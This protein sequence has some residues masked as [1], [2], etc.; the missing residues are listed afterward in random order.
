MISFLL[1]LA[2]SLLLLPSHATAM[3]SLLPDDVTTSFE[4]ANRYR[5]EENIPDELTFR[6]TQS[7]KS[8]YLANIVLSAYADWYS[9]GAISIVLDSGELSGDTIHDGWVHNDRSD[10]AFFQQGYLETYFL[11]SH[12]IGL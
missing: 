10:D 5:F 9:L 4:M 3:L 8:L 12:G 1:I 2:F 7:K 6:W 11:D